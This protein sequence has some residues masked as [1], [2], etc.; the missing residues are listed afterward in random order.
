[1]INENDYLTVAIFYDVTVI[2]PNTNLKTN[3]VAVFVETKNEH[4]AFTFYY[5]YK[6]SAENK[7]TFNTS[8]K[9]SQEQE[10]FNN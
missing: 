4:Q 10:I 8:W 7:L 3:A 5:P 9:T 2:N 1:L 6:L